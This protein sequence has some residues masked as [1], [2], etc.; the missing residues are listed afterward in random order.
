MYG[1]VFGTNEGVQGT[2]IHMWRWTLSSYNDYSRYFP[3]LV[4]SL[5]QADIQVIRVPNCNDIPTPHCSAIERTG[6]VR[7][8]FLCDS[9]KSAPAFNVKQKTA[10]EIGHCLG[11]EHR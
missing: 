1:M 9:F 5:S 11:L 6:S 4:G 2:A 3:S 7:R 8:M 10:Y